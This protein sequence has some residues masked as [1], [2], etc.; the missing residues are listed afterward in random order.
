MTVTGLSRN[1]KMQQGNAGTALRTL[2]GALRSGR[3]ER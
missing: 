3:T 2:E 1:L